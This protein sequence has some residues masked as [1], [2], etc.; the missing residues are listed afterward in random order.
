M[1][2]K[3]FE[4]LLESVKEAKQIL[5]GEV[6]PSREFWVEVPNIKPQRQE[7]FALCIKT[8][9]PELLVTSKIYRAWFLQSGRIR[10]I[11]E[12]GEAAIYPPEFFIKIK[13]PVEVEQILD[14]LQAQAA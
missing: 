13:L 14:D 5:Q 3:D 6:V 10:I 11:D 8:D 4:G 9:D 7:G 12:A 1:N 2:K